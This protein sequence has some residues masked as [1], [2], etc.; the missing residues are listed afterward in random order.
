MDL[1]RDI[2]AAASAPANS[3]DSND[4]NDS[5]GS[6]DMNDTNHTKTGQAARSAPRGRAAPRRTRAPGDELARSALD[7]YVRS[8]AHIKVLSREET[9]V[10]S[11][12][13]EASLAIFCESVLSIPGT[14]LEIL[15][16][17]RSR[18]RAGLVTAALS[19]HYRDG[20]GKDWGKAVD[21][22]MTRLEPLIEER[23]SLVGSTVESSVRRRGELDAEIAKQ[24]GKADIAVSL[25]FEIAKTFRGLL[26]GGRERAAVAARRRRGLTE[27]SA[28]S[29]LAR[30]ETARDELEEVKRTFATHNLRLVVNQAKRYRNMGVPYLDLIQEGN[31]GLLRAVEKFDHRRGF[32]FSTYAVWWIDQALVRA[33]QNVSRTVRVPSHVYELQLRSRRLTQELRQRLGRSPTRDE[34]AEALEV[35]P[36]VV[37]RVMASTMPISSTDAP[38]PGTDDLVLEDVIADESVVD[39]IEDV[40]RGELRHVLDDAVAMLDPR[41]R[42]ILQARFGREDQ[43]IPTLEEIGKRMGISRE[44]VRQLERR[45]L[46][47]LRDRE[48]VRRLYAERDTDLAA[49][50]ELAG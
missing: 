24:L 22:T 20:S 39:P 32:K 44:R 14:A 35:E 40:D 15:E 23:E 26:D 27:A 48:D 38:I 43:D 19:E 16:R 1:E 3:N 47:R 8:I 46:T 49:L 17:W 30:A 28:K 41:E 29:A 6:N 7:H 5:N 31:L 11:R 34:M 36:E 4:S 33:I 42:E 9:Y 10:L 21:R 2:G 45:A 13:M 18:R 25:L 37:D 12:E 50:A